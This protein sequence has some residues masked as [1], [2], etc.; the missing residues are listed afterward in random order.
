MLVLHNS[1]ERRVTRNDNSLF[2]D[3]VL[4][5]P[6]VATVLAV[7]DGQPKRRYIRG[8]EEAAFI[9]ISAR[10]NMRCEYCYY[11]V[12]NSAAFP[13]VSD[14]VELAKSLSFKEIALMGAEPTL[15]PDL[16]E[17]IEEI[18]KYKRVG[19]V[20][21]G[22]KLTDLEFVLKLKAAGLSSVSYSMHYMKDINVS[23][24]RIG[25]LRNIAE[26]RLPLFQL[27]FTLNQIEEI[28][29]VVA[30]IDKLSELAIAPKQVCI[31]AGAAIGACRKDSG[32]WMSDM[33][34]RM[35]SHGAYPMSGCG[36]NLY[37]VEMRYN[38]QQIHLARWPSNSTILPYSD[39]G[40]TF[41]TKRGGFKSPMMQAS[42]CNNDSVIEIESIRRIPSELS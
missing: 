1:I 26:A 28:D 17:I 36:N 18:S 40:P 39:T 21:N 6:D 42:L 24:V 19:M 5:E 23:R 14:V 4:V 32:I 31:R 16:F 34:K 8:F 38:S 3:G 20:T 15:H 9:D 11:P 22:A 25:I 41:V 29:Q 12:D 37:F 35:T 30:V 33:I 13:S 7:V 27:A 2:V 10:C